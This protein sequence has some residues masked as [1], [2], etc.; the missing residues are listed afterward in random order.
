[1]TPRGSVWVQEP[2]PLP[3]SP[4]QRQALRAVVQQEGSY[5]K[6]ITDAE[7]GDADK[8]WVSYGDTH[9]CMAS[10]A[11]SAER[12]GFT[13][14]LNAR[15]AVPAPGEVVK[16]GGLARLTVAQNQRILNFID[17]QLWKGHPVGV[18]V[19]YAP[20]VGKGAA[21]GA[22]DHVVL[23]YARDY[24][25]GTV[26]YRYIENAGSDHPTGYFNVD[27]TTYRLY[28]QAPPYTGGDAY[29][30]QLPFITAVG[31]RPTTLTK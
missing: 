27:A 1:M 26:V 22:T 31:A 9:D 16:A 29:T 25:S 24:V 11:K 14:N 7:A 18:W 10:A 5:W 30:S 6:H 4:D 3:V 28:K 21:D 23:V 17:E 2:H 8:F 12:M 20:G 15:T 19:D 13:L